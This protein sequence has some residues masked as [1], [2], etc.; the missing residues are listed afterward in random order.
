VCAKAVEANPCCVLIPGIDYVAHEVEN[1]MLLAEHH[2]RESKMSNEEIEHRLWRK[3]Q[4]RPATGG[5]LFEARTVGTS[6]V[7]QDVE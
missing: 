6:Y 2:S 1:D 5:R 7:C 3:D 4:L